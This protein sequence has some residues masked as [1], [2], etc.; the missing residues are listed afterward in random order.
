MLDAFE[1]G[2]GFMGSALRFSCSVI[3][4]ID[5]CGEVR[6]DMISGFIYRESI[7]SIDALGR[8]LKTADLPWT[9]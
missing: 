5:T 1:S 6:L 7:F 8:G 4:F 9:L 2:L 3:S